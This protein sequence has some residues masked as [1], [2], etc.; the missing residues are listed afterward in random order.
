MSVAPLMRQNYRSSSRHK[1]IHPRK[2]RKY[3]SR[4]SSLAEKAKIHN[5]ASRQN[6]YSPKVRSLLSLEKISTVVSLCLVTSTLGIYAWTIYIPKLWSQEYRQLE[7]LQRHERQLILA[8][9]SLKNELAQQA[10][11]A[12]SGLD[13]LHP[14]NNLHL[15]ATPVPSLKPSQKDLTKKGDPIIP[16]SPMAY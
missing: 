14:S 11:K 12:E 16:E 4:H 5:L 13:N 3:S 6:K 15:R 10:E 1:K 9:E 8:N 7:T 2:A